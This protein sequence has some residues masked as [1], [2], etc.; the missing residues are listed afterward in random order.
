MTK[1]SPLIEHK[2]LTQSAVFKLMP[3]VSAAAVMIWG[4]L[5]AVRPQQCLLSVILAAVLYLLIR[6]LS[7]SKIQFNKAI[8]LMLTVEF[9]FLQGIFWSWRVSGGWGMTK[10][11]SAEEV[12]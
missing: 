6:F 12:Y 10:D 4:S 8:L 2:T 11:I 7:Y 9:V 3:A 5:T 1:N